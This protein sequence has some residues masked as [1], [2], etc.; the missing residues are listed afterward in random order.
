M[1]D[2]P[3]RNAF[4]LPGGKIFVFTG[5]LSVAHNEDG[6]AAVV[7]HEM[8]HQIANHPAETIAKYRL[9][10]FAQLLL[11]SIFPDLRYFFSRSFLDLVFLKPNSRYECSWLINRKMET[12]ADKIGVLLMHKAG[13]RIEEA[14]NMWRRMS[15]AGD[16]QPMEFVSTHPAHETR[17]RDLLLLVKELRRTE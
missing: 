3:V 5:I 14:V 2:L 8:S 7:S 4:V 13:Y 10:S 6:L 9:L 17:I 1:V 12:E 15:A 11:V 16:A